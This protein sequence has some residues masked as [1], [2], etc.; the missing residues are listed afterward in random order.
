MRLG[1]LQTSSGSKVFSKLSFFFF[2]RKKK[3]NLSQQPGSGVFG[4]GPGAV[5]GFIAKPMGTGKGASPPC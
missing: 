3:G 5:Q 4:L 2:F 1:C